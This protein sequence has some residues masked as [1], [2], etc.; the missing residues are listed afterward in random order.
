MDFSWQLATVRGPWRQMAP[1]TTVFASTRVGCITWVV[2]H[3]RNVMSLLMLRT[4]DATTV[5]RV[6]W[7]SV[8]LTLWHII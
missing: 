1:S 8:L 3:A 5:L 7:H 2:F 6:L 4:D